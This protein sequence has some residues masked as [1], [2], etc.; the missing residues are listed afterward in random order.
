VNLLVTG[1]AGYIGSVVAAELL[2]SG[3][4]VVIFDNLSKGW[5]PAVPAGATFV[6]GDVS[7]RPQIDHVFRSHSIEAVLHFAALAEAG[8]SMQVPE[9]YFRIN[10]AGTLTLLESMLEHGVR[11]L[12][13]SSTAA[14]YGEPEQV[15]IEETAPLRP[16]NAYGESKLIA[17]RMLD[18][19]H[20]IH[21][22]RVASLRYFNAAG[23]SDGFGEDHRPETHLIPLILKV[24]LGQQE[25]I[26]IFGTDYRTRD[27]SCIRDYIHVLDLAS[28]H[29]L[30]LEALSHRAR[31]AYNLGNGRGFSVREVVE[32][33]RRVT[34]HPIPALEAP[35]RKGDPAVLVA[36]SV[37]IQQ[38]LSWQPKLSDL[39]AII[40]SAWEW[41]RAHPGGYE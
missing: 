29:L 16:T 8:E 6:S 7:S 25:Q 5:R 15:P 3:H 2:K 26:R 38:E 4:S 13:F 17:E 36:S 35:R 18:W 21:G 11:R 37:K 9:R 33:A 39:E 32:T 10:S 1:G 31:L 23:S 27:G 20:N 24:A 19:F 40:A 28:A 14:V 41:Q 22:L 30:A 12:V 34:G